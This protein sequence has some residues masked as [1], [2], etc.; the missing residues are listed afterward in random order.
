MSLLGTSKIHALAQ[1][2][3]P[4]S[5][6]LCYI[7]NG[8]ASVWERKMP[9]KNEK[10]LNLSRCHCSPW[11][12]SSPSHG[13]VGVLGPGPCSNLSHKGS[14]VFLL[15]LLQVM[16]NVLIQASWNNEQNIPRNYLDQQLHTCS[17]A[18]PRPP[19]QN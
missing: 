15:P 6:I 18:Q 3:C 16:K 17:L 13:P 4:F 19:L 12:K 9:S 14:T 11:H 8:F 7:T 2:Y 5:F 1:W 10:S